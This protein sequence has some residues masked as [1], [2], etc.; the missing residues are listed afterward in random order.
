MREWAPNVAL[1]DGTLLAGFTEA[2]L[3]T[4]ALVLSGSERDGRSLA[5]K[6]DDGRGWLRKDATGQELADAIS[7]AMRGDAGATTM[8][9]T[10]GLTVIVVACIIV[11]LLVAY[12]IWLAVS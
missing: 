1:V 5:R 3:G 8:V 2:S 6:L 7:T 9:G 4:P 11:L 12:L 10:I